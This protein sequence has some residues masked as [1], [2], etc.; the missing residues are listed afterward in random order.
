MPCLKGGYAIGMLNLV[1]C[2]FRERALSGTPKS[3]HIGSS[4]FFLPLP[5]TWLCKIV[6]LWWKR[7]NFQGLIHKEQS[8]GGP[9][10][11]TLPAPPHHDTLYQFGQ[12]REV[13]EGNT[14]PHEL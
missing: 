12:K 14:E 9:R 4:Y 11:G 1:A 7:G 8:A 6:R 3:W 10:A 5:Y 2:L 13:G